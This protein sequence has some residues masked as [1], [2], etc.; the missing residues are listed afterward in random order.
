[1]KRI[2][3]FAALT[4]TGIFQAQSQELEQKDKPDEQITIRK[5]YDENGN[6]IQYD[7]TYVYEWHSDSAFQLPFDDGVFWGGDIRQLMEKFFND[8]SIAGFG[9]PHHFIFPF[10]DGDLFSN[11]F[12]F[13]FP[14]SLLFRDFGWESDSIF[15]RKFSFHQPPH[16]FYGFPELD[17]IQK[18]LEEHFK[19]FDEPSPRFRSE[20][21]QKEWEELMDK[22]QKEKEELMKKWKNE[23]K[24]R[25]N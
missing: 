20:Q 7:S 4:L 9:V 12:N 5:E 3:V 15:N 14:D 8:S 10:D 1:M 2:L 13:G 16:G 22:Q 23:L 11:P 19:Y 18:Q 17:E 24:L 25:E 21:Q 6:L